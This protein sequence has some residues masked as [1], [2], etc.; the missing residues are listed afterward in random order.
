MS[1]QRFIVTGGAGFLGSHLIDRLLGDGHAGLCIDNFS[2]GHP[3]NL[4]SHGHNPAY[5][6]VVHD[7][8]QRLG[9]V[10]LQDVSGIFH[11]ACPA[12]PTHYQ[13]DPIQTTRTAV[14]GTLNMLDLAQ[15]LD[16]PLLLASTS[17]VYG[18]P[19]V[20][21]Q[22]EHYWG[23]VNPIGPRAC[24]DEG[25]RCAES[26]CFDYARHR[27]VSVKVTRIFNTYGPR[28]QPND[29]RVISNL[30]TQALQGKPLTLYGD[31]LQTRSFCYVD[32]L[33]D[34]L[35]R[36]MAHNQP[37]DGPVN[38]GNPDEIRIRD[39]ARQILA[40]TGRCTPLVHHPLPVDDP[41]QR[42][43]D[44]SRARELLGWQP[45]TSLVKGL[46]QTIQAFQHTTPVHTH[47]EVYV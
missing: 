28:M 8:T 41:Q 1:R 39:L 12:S 43:P 31:G 26:L 32:D 17:E 20:H 29:G 38:L 33:V 5:S 22:P 21:P 7:V 19:A 24:Y 2:T 14:L 45:Y 6:L 13:S 3:A 4:T 36:L 47:G 16:I 15:S 37:L 25:K 42:C 44:I 40:L 23:H 9:Q 34:G 10:D 30:I 27:G 11:L 35:V 46:Q 18:N